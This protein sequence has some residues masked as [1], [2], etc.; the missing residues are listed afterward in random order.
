MRN[1]GT[2]P[3]AGRFIRSP[4]ACAAC[5]LFVASLATAAP[6]STLRIGMPLVPETL[7]PVRADNMQAFMVI[8]GVFDTLFVIDPLSRPAAIVPG[9]AA[10][11]PEV[12]ADY[13]TYTLRIRPGI[14]FTPHPAFGG[15]ERELVAADVAYAIRRVLDPKLR[16]PTAYLLDGK[17][18]GLDELAARARAAGRALDYEAP[19]NGLVVVDRHTLRVRL[20]APDPLFPYVLAFPSLSPVAREVIDAE[21]EGH[22]L[23]PIGTG[24]FLV[25]SFVPGQ[26]LTLVRN[27]GYRPRRG[28][29]L[30]TPASRA[31]NP[32]HAM[33]RGFLP[34]LDRVEV[35]YTPE[36][37][38]E[39]MALRRN[40]LDLIALDGPELALRNGRLRPD[41]ADDGVQ[42]VRAASPS[43][44]LL[45]FNMR[46]PVVGGAAIERIALRRAIQM[47]Y[48]DEEMRRVF[49]GGLSD[50]RHQVVPPGI[51]GH[52]AGYRNP[53]RF[54]PVAANALLDRYGYRRGPDGRRRQP[55]GSALTLR[56][57]SGSSSGSRRSMEFTR[58]MLDRIG[59]RVEFESVTGGERLKRMST[60]RYGMAV[61]DMGLDIPDGS[62][63]MVAFRS[64]AIGSLNLAC[65][66]DA[67]FDATYE[68]AIAM[69]AGRGRDELFRTMQAR[70]DALGPARPLPVADLLLL[71]R[72][73]VVGPFPT[74]NDWLQLVTVGVEG[75]PRPS[76]AR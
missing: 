46:D 51:E 43:T 74:Y 8:A 5:W 29:D 13:R 21:G 73:H 32:G 44:L 61:M 19:V 15:K 54:D 50:L 42:L 18:E 39:L 30:L 28:D 41:L 33:R 16:S 3:T 55:D 27:P 52:V 6:S 38:A 24:A 53:N 62:N 65:F 9:A 75:P 23:R 63:M 20:N 64:K 1:G 2:R 56:V 59:L 40:E 58:R 76:N 7:D 66:A 14:Q 36:P 31:S 70:L 49:D 72:R 71:K 45:Y 68:R 47:A 17:I 69:P 26:R 4:L 25:E 60:C 10:S 57:L 22:G 48:D 35:S 12:S 37:A 34:R 11:L 67:E